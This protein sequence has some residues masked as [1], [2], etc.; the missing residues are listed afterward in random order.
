MI[1]ELTVILHGLT[2]PINF[3][4]HLCI[5]LG[6]FY[7]ALHNRNLPAWHITPLWYLGLTH[8]LIAITVIVQW[9]IGPEHPLSYWNFGVIGETLSDMALAAIVIVMWV[10]TLR[11]DFIGRNKRL[12][13]LHK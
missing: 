1:T 6:S 13:S 12:Q 4:C 3:V 7:V 2:L 10:V 5:W 11:H 8:L 9:T